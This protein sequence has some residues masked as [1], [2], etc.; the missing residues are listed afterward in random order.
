METAIKPGIY[1]ETLADGNLTTRTEDA[2]D[3]ARFLARNEGLFV[4]ISS[5]AAVFAAIQLARTLTEG[6]VVTIL[7][8]SG[9]KYLSERFWTEE[10]RLRC[11]APP[12]CLASGKM[13]L[14]ITTNLL[15]Q[16]KPMA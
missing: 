2:Y 11:Q 13:M 15:D 9:M 16:I 4:G 8:D 3:M 5:A 1:D 10:Y 7:P 6:L 14:R 12:R